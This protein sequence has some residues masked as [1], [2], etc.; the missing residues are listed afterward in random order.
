MSGIDIVRR[1]LG[2]NGLSERLKTLEMRRDLV[3][4]LERR[5][6]ASSAE[7]I[8]R[9]M[10]NAKALDSNTA[11]MEF[12]LRALP[13]RSGGIFC[14]FGVYQGKSLNYIAQRIQTRVYGFDSF[15]GLPEPWRDGF[16][17]GAF[18]VDAGKLP[19][20]AP[21]AELVVGLFSDTLPQ[22]TADHSGDV[23][24]IHIDCDLY[25]ST[26]TILECLGM[27]LAVGSVIVFDEYFN[28][29]GWQLHEH[30]AFREF[31][32]QT[33]RHFEYLCFN[34]F[35]EQVALRML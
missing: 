32:D 10:H 33:N 24:F 6:T 1:V 15:R 22:F 30:R 3:H 19:R 16:S 13:S 31:I 17:E 14:E 35:H 12:A 5:A 20:C 7:F 26:R 29:P 4:E 27:R 8:E 9:H 11:V 18:Q 25:S 2:I 23:S 34:R 21:N 28:Y